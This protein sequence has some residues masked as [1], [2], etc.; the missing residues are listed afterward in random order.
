VQQH[1]S[2]VAAM[3]V[4][5]NVILGGSGPLKPRVARRAVQALVQEL[6]FTL[7]AD[8][9]VR[10]LSVA[11]QQRL[12]ILKA[13][14][15]K[16]RLLILDEPT[17]ILAPE[18]ATELYAWLRGFASHG[19]TAIVVTHKLA[20]ARRYTDDLTVLRAGRTVLQSPS[21][22]KSADDL[23]HAMIGEAVAPAARG[24]K[25]ATGASLVR[26]KQLSLRDDRHVTVVR[27]A[28]FELL[29][30]EILGIAG[31]EGSGHHHLLLAMAGRHPASGGSI[32]LARRASIIPEDRHRNAVVL[33]FSLVENAAISN[34]G[35]RR[36]VLSW[37]QLSERTAAL[38][39]QFDVRAPG[40]DAPMRTLSGGNQQKFVL[41][42][43]LGDQP[44]VIIAE[45]P[46]RGLDIR[47]AAFVR[48][49]LRT[50]RDSGVAVAL[51]SS[52]LD[53]IMELADRVIVVQG[54][55]VTEVDKD[56]TRIG[57]AMLGVA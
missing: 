8:A 14:F 52:D 39:D 53:E 20:E 4:W 32:E 1:P 57:A 22:L 35:G 25:R 50:A 17:A 48:Q 23:T 37:S 6:R 51:Y 19:G 21:A 10:D 15:R 54:G 3:T 38:I 16:A 5:E 44:E 27:D 28:S 13:V 11:A 7:D 40:P 30:G 49:Q 31:V 36:G 46:T 24:E 42:R 2:N 47:A 12:E 26:A 33:P 56:R 18:E 41:A 55:R 9:L 45:N 34:A 29:G 43:E